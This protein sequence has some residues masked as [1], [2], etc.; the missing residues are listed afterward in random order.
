MF[1]GGNKSTNLTKTNFKIISYRAHQYILFGF[2]ENT[3]FKKIKFALRVFQI[4]KFVSRMTC[5]ACH[6]R[7]QH[8]IILKLLYLLPH[9]KLEANV[10]QINFWLLVRPNVMEHLD[11]SYC[12][13]T[14][15][16]FC[17][18]KG[19]II[20]KAINAEFIFHQM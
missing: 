17:S 3:A 14:I 1:K 16:S 11:R 13:Y 5:Y 9:K 12:F 4:I 6:V 15:Q 10:R 8:K 7:R 20:A 18:K 2:V 19:N